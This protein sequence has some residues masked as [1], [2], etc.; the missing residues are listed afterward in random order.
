MTKAEAQQAAA[1]MNSQ[2]RTG[3]LYSAGVVLHHRD[4]HRVLHWTVIYEPP[5]STPRQR[6]IARLLQPFN[7]YAVS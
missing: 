7:P 6:E 2:C 3:G 4:I 5:V 1:N